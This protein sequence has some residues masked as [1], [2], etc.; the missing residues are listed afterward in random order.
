LNI[1]SSIMKH[2]V[3]KSKKKQKKKNWECVISGHTNGALLCLLIVFF[4][5]NERVI[6]KEG[7]T[8]FG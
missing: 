5:Y 7:H 1:E 8:V 3:S 2:K 6:V 4:M